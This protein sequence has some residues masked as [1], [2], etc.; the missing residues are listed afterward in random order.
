[1]KLYHIRYPIF[2]NS[3]RSDM[4]GKNGAR[5]MYTDYSFMRYSKSCNLKVLLYDFIPGG[6]V[7]GV[8]VVGVV[9]VGIPHPAGQVT[10][11]M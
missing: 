1:M 4:L 11:A 7:V 10:W 8:V 3:L 9:V 2:L 5:Y 6:V